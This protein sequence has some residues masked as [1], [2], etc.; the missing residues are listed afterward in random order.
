MNK[1]QLPTGYL[2][3]DDYDKGQL[4]TLSIGDYGKH[5]NV[6]ANFLG[7]SEMRLANDEMKIIGIK[8]V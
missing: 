8:K 5:I 2:F 3:T 6:K 4:E 7:G 1:I